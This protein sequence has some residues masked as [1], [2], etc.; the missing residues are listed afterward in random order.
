VRPCSIRPLAGSATTSSAAEGEAP[1]AF[2]YNQGTFVGAANFLGFTNEAALAANYTMNQMGR[3]GLL[4]QSGENGDGGGFNG[5]AVRW[6]ARF[7]KDRELQ[8]TY[9]AWL[10]RN[11]DAAWNV[12]RQSDNLSWCRW[13]EPT[14]PGPRYSWGCS[15]SVVILQLVPPNSD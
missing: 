11:A 4:P 7:M 1:R 6:I 9:L 10:Q 2:T 15:S 13:L 14:P 8:G 3:D 12:R 5:I